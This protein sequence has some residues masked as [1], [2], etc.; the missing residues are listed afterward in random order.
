MTLVS[1]FVDISEQPQIPAE[2]L[3]TYFLM[4]FTNGKNNPSKTNK[5]KTFKELFYKD[6]CG[7]LLLGK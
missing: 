6:P 5:K 1:C 4:E 3:N 7:V 2:L